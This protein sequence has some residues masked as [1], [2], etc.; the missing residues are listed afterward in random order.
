M[1]LFVS[2]VTDKWL[3]YHVKL[4]A[5]SANGSGIMPL[6]SLHGSTLQRAWGEIFCVWHHFL[7][8]ISRWILLLAKNEQYNNVT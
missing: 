8:N 4:S 3:I 2:N 7:T 6:N 1:T 5:Y